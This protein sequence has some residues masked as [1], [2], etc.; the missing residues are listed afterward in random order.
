MFSESNYNSISCIGTMLRENEILKSLVLQK[1]R[2]SP[3]GLCEVCS[4]LRVNT[5]LTSLDTSGNKFDD[6]SIASLSYVSSLNCG[7]VISSAFMVSKYTA[8]C[9]KYKKAEIAMLTL[10]NIV[11]LL[12]DIEH[13]TWLDFRTLLHFL[14]MLCDKWV[15]NTNSILGR[16]SIMYTKLTKSNASMIHWFCINYIY[17]II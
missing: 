8:H 9:A 16:Q 1:C 10:G 2:I 12:L 15:R 13:S 14:K 11:S 5:T 3:E 17:S 6:H 7:I 4:P